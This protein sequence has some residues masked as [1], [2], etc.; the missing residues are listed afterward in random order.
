MTIQQILADPSASFWLCDALTSSLKRDPVD[1][2]TDLEI[3]RQV[4]ENRIA[5]AKA[6]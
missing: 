1:V 3:L 4:S 6:E 2:L 5:E